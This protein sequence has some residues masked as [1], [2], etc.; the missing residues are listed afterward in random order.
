MEDFV[1]EELD[2][3]NQKGLTEENEIEVH[4]EEG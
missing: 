4:D 1:N 2:Y 3:S